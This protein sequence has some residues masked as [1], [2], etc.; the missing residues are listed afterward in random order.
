MHANPEVQ[1]LTYGLLVT[2][3][4]SNTAVSPEI[5]DCLASNIQYLHDH[6]EAHERGEILSITRRL[7]RRL[8]NSALAIRRS[9]KDDSVGQ[10]C[11]KTLESYTSFTKRFY[12]FLKGEMSTGV[13]YPRH[14]LGLL[15]LQLLLDLAPD[16]DAAL[17]DAGL[18]ATLVN[19]VLD[20]FED[21][22][23]AAT[24]LLLSLSC[25]FSEF[26]ADAINPHFLQHLE[27]MTI[28]T[29]RADHADAFGRLVALRSLCATQVRA[30]PTCL[31]DGL[32]EHLRRLEQL[33]SPQS[34]AELRPGCST[35][36]HGEMLSVS[37][38]LRYSIVPAD[39][40]SHLASL[41]LSICASVW[42]Q[43]RGQLCVDS[44]ERTTEIDDE[45]AD[46]GPKDLLA[47]SW[48]ALRDS[49]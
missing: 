4:A 39:N 11:S 43:V 49:R 16:C 37:Y 3:P 31:K 19:L 9:V 22:R 48:R 2:S 30:V 12:D 7:L 45:M 32:I 44:P 47:Y 42:T 28:R 40:M 46:E 34:G 38:R 13:S 20:P 21:V 23:A 36:I 8:R 27:A 41:L 5:L 29:G 26:V 6:A 10:T 18:V 35:A 17:V 14:I 33:T 1:I 15:S 25:N 24:N